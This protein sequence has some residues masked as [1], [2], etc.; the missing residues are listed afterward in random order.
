MTNYPSAQQ[1]AS[2]IR[3]HVAERSYEGFTGHAPCKLHHGEVHGNRHQSLGDY[4]AVRWLGI[5]EH[6]MFEDRSSAARD[7]IN[8]ANTAM[9]S[10][11]GDVLAAR[12]Y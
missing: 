4:R 8:Q 6:Y 2:N 7:F 5:G 1:R 3:V 10:V 12:K 11:Q 9:L